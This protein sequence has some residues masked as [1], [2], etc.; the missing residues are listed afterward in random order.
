MPAPRYRSRSLRRIKV[1]TA[2][3]VTTRY[4]KRKPSKSRCSECG[5]DLKGITRVRATKL[6]AIAKSKKSPSRPF[7]NLCSSCSRKKLIQRAKETKW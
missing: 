5:K 4:R 2:S 7:A 3:K 6:K 1:K